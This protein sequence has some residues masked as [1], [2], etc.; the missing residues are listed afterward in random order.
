VLLG[1]VENVAARVRR[2]GRRAGS[3]HLKI[4]FGEFQTITR[5]QTLAEPTDSTE[6]LW[7]AAKKILETWAEKSFSPVRLIGIQASSLIDEPAQL[8][9]FL[10]SA[11]AKKRDLDRAVDAIN[12]RHGKS[13]VFRGGARHERD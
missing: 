10:D 8:P 11:S 2:N 7:H 6:R 12:Q 13:T 3:V 5:S 9:L 4:R 1:Q